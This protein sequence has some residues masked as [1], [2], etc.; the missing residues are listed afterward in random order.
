MTP[1]P[2]VTE[3]SRFGTD[4][5]ATVV[6]AT[7][8][9]AT[10]DPARDLA[11]R[12]DDPQV[13][14]SLQSL[15]DHADLLAVLLV[16]LD[17]LIRRGDTIAD[18]LA[19][20]VSELRSVQRPDG[21]PDSGQLLDA[22][23]KLGGMLEPTLDVLPTFEYLLRSDM[24]DRRVIDVAAMA[25]RAVLAGSETSAAA[26]ARQ[27]RPG[28]FGLWRALRDDDTRRALGFVLAV[29]KSLG[30]ELRGDERAAGGPDQP[31]SPARTTRTASG[32]A[33]ADIH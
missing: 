20:G 15:L 28:I 6:A 30:Q 13:V 23:R 8:V 4:R 5:R 3:G 25:S 27:R 22:A 24:G 7:H 9:T 29:A 11:A 33:A 12:L 19:E 32:P 14:Q 16:G 1:G 2:I 31:A 18:S 26:P 17:G 10:P 21:L